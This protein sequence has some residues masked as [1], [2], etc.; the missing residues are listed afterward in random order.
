MKEAYYSTADIFEDV[1]Q[2]SAGDSQTH[3][4]ALGHC[5]EGRITLPKEVAQVGTWDTSLYGGDLPL[6]IK[7]EYYELSPSRKNRQ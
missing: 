6:D 7:D 3:H 5:P 1:A 4:P 2:H